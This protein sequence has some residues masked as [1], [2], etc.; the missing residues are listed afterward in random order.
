MLVRDPEPELIEALRSFVREVRI[1]PHA[2]ASIPQDVHGP[3]LHTLPFTLRGA[4]AHGVLFAAS[5][6]PCVCL[7][8]FG[9][10]QRIGRSLPPAR[11]RA[12]VVWL[13][14]HGAGIGRSIPSARMRTVLSGCF[15][16]AARE[17]APFTAPCVVV[18]RDIAGRR[19][20]VRSWALTRTST[21]RNCPGRLAVAKLRRYHAAGSPRK[22]ARSELASAA[23]TGGGPQ[24]PDPGLATAA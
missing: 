15:G 3:S 8:V 5:C 2:D 16:S 13:L 1:P 10:V 24:A 7:A 21:L 19:T 17:A 22:G 11:M 6:A 9:T 4:R 23:A 14:W 18:G 20:R 12:C